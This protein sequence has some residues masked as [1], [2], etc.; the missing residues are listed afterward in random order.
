MT[1]PVAVP[2]LLKSPALRPKTDSLKSTSKVRLSSLVMLS[3]S[4]V[5]L[6]EP[7][8]PGKR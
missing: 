7:A 6:S 5:P 1:Q 3:V 2:W 4:E 8:C